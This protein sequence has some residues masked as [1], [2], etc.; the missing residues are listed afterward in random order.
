MAFCFVFRWS[1]FV[2]VWLALLLPSTLEG[3]STRNCH[4]LL[5]N[6]A[7]VVA[8]YTYCAV[9]NSRPFRFCCRCE[10]VYVTALNGHRDIV[11]NDTCH[12]DLVMAEQ[13]QIVESAYDFVVHLWESSHCPGRYTGI[14]RLRILSFRWPKTISLFF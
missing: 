1:I 5:T 3:Q 8:N 12:G 7:E 10:E 11:Q 13:Y 9:K 4:K 14:Y 6:F 2:S